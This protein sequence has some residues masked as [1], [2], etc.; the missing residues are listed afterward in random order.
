MYNYAVL[1]KG[2]VK[3]YND[4][5]LGSDLSI[6]NAARVSFGKRVEQFTDKDEKLIKYLIEHKHF[7]PFR[8]QYITF[9]IKWPEFV[10]RQAYKHIVGASLTSLEAHKD[11]GWNEISGRYTEYKDFHIPKELRKQ[12]KDNKQASDGLIDYATSSFFVSSMQ[13]HITA[14][15][16]LYDL[17]L[18]AGVAREQ[19]REVLPVSFYT[20][21]YWTASFQAIMNFI[22]LRDK[23]DAQLEIR[24]Y[25]I[26]MSDIVNKTFPKASLWWRILIK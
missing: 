11:T 10:A 7:S 3:V 25:A 14:S 13:K 17:M 15:L 1:D 5:I 23:P 20:E 19:A 12:S 26:V 22:T 9:H 24:E 2:F 18:Q 21:C 16:E 6:V 8:H 4:G